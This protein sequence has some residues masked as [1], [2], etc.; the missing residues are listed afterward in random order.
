MNPNKIFFG[1][2]LIFLGIV[3]L[4]ISN[5]AEFGG[6]ILFGPIPIVIASSPSM[7]FFAL[8]LVLLILLIL[9]V[10]RW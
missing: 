10:L 4:S 8:I 2:L 9:I 7:A 6:V 1:F 5:G 3:L